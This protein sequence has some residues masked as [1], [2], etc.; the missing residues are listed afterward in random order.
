MA[1]TQTQ[2]D[3]LKA[4]YARGVRSVTFGDRTTVYQSQAE[5]A[6]AIARIEAELARSTTPPRPRQWAGWSKKGL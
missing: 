4:A 1:W 3:A 2:L 5:M 6:E